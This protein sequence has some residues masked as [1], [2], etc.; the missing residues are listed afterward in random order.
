MIFTR[1]LKKYKA[2]CC[3]LVPS[4]SRILSLLNMGRVCARKSARTKLRTIRFC[5]LI[6]G[7]KWES[8]VFD[9]MILH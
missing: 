5:I 3:F 7:S 6:K 4:K 9:Q 1:F 2:R 8:N